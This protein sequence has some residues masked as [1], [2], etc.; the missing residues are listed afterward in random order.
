MTL[1]MDCELPKE[2]NPLGWHNWGKT[3]NEKTVRYC[4]H[5]NSGAGSDTSQRVQW[6]KKLDENEARQITLENVMGDFY[7][8]IAN[9]I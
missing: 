3:A 4:E 6:M 2:I 9:K 1:F 8:L 7:K 5:N